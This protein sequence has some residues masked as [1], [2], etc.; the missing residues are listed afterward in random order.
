MSNQIV[1]IPNTIIATVLDPIDRLGG[2]GRFAPALYASFKN[3]GEYSNRIS[4]LF[5][6]QHCDDLNIKYLHLQSENDASAKYGLKF[7]G[8]GTMRKIFSSTRIWKNVSAIRC[9]ERLERKR[10]KDAAKKRI[11]IDKKDIEVIHAHDY[12][13]M[14]DLRGMNSLCV[15]T[16]HFKGSFY[17]ESARHR[18][19]MDCFVWMKYFEKLE[20]NAIMQADIMTFP[21]ESAKELLIE[22]FPKYRDVIERKS[23][24]VYSGIERPSEAMWIAGNAHNCEKY[25]LNIGNH[26]PDKGVD[27]ALICFIKLYSKC[28]NVRFINIGSYGSETNRINEIAKKFGISHRVDLL[29]V[30]SFGE[31]IKYLLNAQVLIHAPRRVVFDLSLLEAMAL[32]VPVIATNVKGNVEALGIDHPLYIEH[33]N[34]MVRIVFAEKNIDDRDFLQRVSKCEIERYESKFTVEKM[35]YSYAEVYREAIKAK[36]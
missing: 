31:V 7:L 30:V 16:N 20:T 34:G 36:K 33:D 27:A 26:I 19:G 2:P 18:K 15:Y 25:V 11:S 29:G 3:A 1:E 23:K 12:A 22:D 6:L 9:I 21:S 10:R 35:L 17:M 5:N 14:K 4:G 24:I 32:G 13:I 28:D 8:W